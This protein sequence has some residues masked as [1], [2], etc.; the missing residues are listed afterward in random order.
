M[1]LQKLNITAKYVE[2]ELSEKE[3]KIKGVPIFNGKLKISPIAYL[4]LPV[5]KMW[6]ERNLWISK[7]TADEFRKY[8]QVLVEETVAQIEKQAWI[9]DSKKAKIIE[10]IE[11]IN[12]I[13]F[14]SESLRNL[15]NVEVAISFYF[16]C[17]DS[18]QWDLF[19][20][21]DGQLTKSEAIADVEGTRIALKALRKAV[22]SSRSRSAH[23][24]SDEEIEDTMSDCSSSPLLD[25]DDP[26]FVEDNAS[27]VSINLT[28]QKVLSAAELRKQ[29]DQR[30]HNV[31]QRVNTT[32]TNCRVVLGLN[33]WDNVVVLEKL[34][35]RNGVE[36]ALEARK[37][38]PSNGNP[39]ARGEEGCCDVC[40]EERIETMLFDC[41]TR[42]CTP[43]L[44][45]H[46]FTEV[47]TNEKFYVSCPGFNCGRLMDDELVRE[48]LAR[49]EDGKRNF[50]RMIVNNFVESD[51]REPKKW[52]PAPNCGRAVKVL[53][54]PSIC[55]V[56]IVRCDC[57]HEFCFTCLHDRHEP[58]SCDNLRRWREQ[59]T[60]DDGTLHWIKA[61]TKKCPKCQVNIEKN[62]GCLHIRC[63]QASCRYQFCWVC[64]KN[65][66]SNSHEECRGQ[67]TNEQYENTFDRSAASPDRIIPYY[68]LF[69]V[70]MRSL[71]SNANIF[72]KVK[73]L[74][75]YI[76]SID[77][78]S[79]MSFLERAVE[80]LV[81]CRKTLAYSYPF[82]YYVD[83]SN[84]V[85]IFEDNQADLEVAVEQLTAYLETGGF[86]SK[87]INELRRN[88]NDKMR[89]ADKRRK[90]LLKQQE[91]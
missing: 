84:E 30:I 1:D 44:Q 34:T 47:S 46:F 37:L 81:K 79:S 49:N 74:K 6:T 73:L 8:A 66:Q 11:K 14:V 32:A 75:E 22:F 19:F 17:C 9:P 2:V 7:A 18:P 41:G 90:A 65:W 69:E 88:I 3:K 54:D 13:L 45:T 24:K 85:T 87:D 57:G 52:C 72:Q 39:V 21:P 62:G 70:H 76:Q 60:G 38:K 15:N 25:I 58:V 53:Q 12:Q 80:L 16:R 4:N 23:M 86:E 31:K 61:Y 27:E 89:Y 48:L 59:T 64:L 51:E 33:K 5:A 82:A 40:I 26:E 67:G 63:T 78:S 42:A 50:E 36:G 91:S 28:N 35:D 77:A 55:D 83:R 29:V 56:N 43:C 20:S 10:S 68:K 71:E